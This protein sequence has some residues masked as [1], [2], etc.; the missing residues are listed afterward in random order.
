M[1]INMEKVGKQARSASRQL[2]RLSRERKDAVL[3]TIAD[4]L[5]AASDEILAA[6]ANDIA[7]GKNAGLTVEQQVQRGCP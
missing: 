6:N 7:A 1:K 3:Q 4:G 5:R 2:A